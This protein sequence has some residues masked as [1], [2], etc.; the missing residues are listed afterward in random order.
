M[1]LRRYMLALLRERN[2][3]LKRIAESPEWRR[4]LPEVCHG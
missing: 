1:L 2:A 4:Y 3:A